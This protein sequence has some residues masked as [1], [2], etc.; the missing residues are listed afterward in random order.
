[1]KKYENLRLKL[2]KQKNLEKLEALS[3]G[4]KPKEPSI[5]KKETDDS[6]PNEVLQEMGNILSKAKYFLKSEKAKRRPRYKTPLK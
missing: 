5:T 1:M 6:I 2:N 4:P 3:V